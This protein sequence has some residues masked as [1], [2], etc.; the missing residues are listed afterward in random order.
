MKMEIIAALLH[1]PQIVLLD[2]PTIG[3]DVISQSKIR[4]FV[5][6]YNEEHKTTFLLTSHYM[7]DIQA[8]CERVFVI[9]RGEGLYDGNFKELVDKIKPHKKLIFEFPNAPQEEVVKALK[10]E[11]N[12]QLVRNILTS[13]LPDEKLIKLLSKLFKISDPVSFSVEELPVE[14]TMKS[15]FENPEKFI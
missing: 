8:L 1:K 6:F 2:E 9:H 12:F 14:E 11:F 7:N 4:E 15:F 3:L 5:K 10:L 13:Q